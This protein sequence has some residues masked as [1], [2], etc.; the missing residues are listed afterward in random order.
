MGQTPKL[1][2][3]FGL[4]ARLPKSGEVWPEAERKLDSSA[5]GAYQVI[6]MNEKRSIFGPKMVRFPTRIAGNVCGQFHF[7]AGGH[8]WHIHSIIID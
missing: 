3:S 1:I 8:S 5:T 7:H 6:A 4:L 2:Q